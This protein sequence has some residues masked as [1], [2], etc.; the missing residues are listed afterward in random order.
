MGQVETDEIYVGVDKR[1]VQYVFPL[2]AKGGTDRLNVVQIE[3]DFGVCAT[4]FPAL[5]CRP[6]GAQ[7]MS[8]NVIALFEFE[9][10]EDGTRVSA[11]K[12]YKL[13]SPDDVTD[14]DLDSY[15]RRTGE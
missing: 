13:V 5:V 6:I 11:E 7:F 4:K 14:A 9:E 15:R 3:Q 10:G 1:G 12:H 2:Q 8:N